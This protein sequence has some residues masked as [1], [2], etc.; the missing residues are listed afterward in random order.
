MRPRYEIVY[1]LR[2]GNSPQDKNN[3]LASL[4]AAAFRLRK[5]IDKM[6]GD[7][8]V[9]CEAGLMHAARKYLMYRNT[10]TEAAKAVRYAYRLSGVPQ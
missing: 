7:R 3:A 8:L 9:S 6:D 10:C 2:G 4:W 5:T 1:R